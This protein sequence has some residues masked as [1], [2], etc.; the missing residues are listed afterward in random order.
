MKRGDKVVCIDDSK[1]NKRCTC[2]CPVQKGK[3][4]VIEE[5]KKAQGELGV[6]LIGVDC[7]H[8]PNCAG[9]P[10]YNGYLFANRFRLLDDLKAENKAKAQ[11]ISP[12]MGKQVKM[13]LA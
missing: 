6:R 1:R 9:Y 2:K 5:V 7:F 4:Y 11:T 12:T 13:S 8:K 10:I 3:I